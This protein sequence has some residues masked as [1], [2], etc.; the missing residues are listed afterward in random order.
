[1]HKKKRKKAGKRAG[2][3]G[4]IGMPCNKRLNTGNSKQYT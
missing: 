1:M 2:H 4:S 3:D